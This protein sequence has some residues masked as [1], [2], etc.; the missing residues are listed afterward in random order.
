MINDD[1]PYIEIK[2]NGEIHRITLAHDGM[3]ADALIDK[4]CRLL[5]CA[6]FPPSVLDAEDKS[7]SWVWLHNNE[8]VV[9]REEGDDAGNND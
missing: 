4:F 2:L 5:V 3:S 6:G 8:Q 1:K 7:G 9:P